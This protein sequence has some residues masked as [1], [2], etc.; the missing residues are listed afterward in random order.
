[1]SNRS[2][3]RCGGSSPLWYAK[4]DER[5]GSIPSI[6]CTLARGLPCKRTVRFRDSWSY[7]LSG[8]HLVVAQLGLYAACPG[9][10]GADLKSVGCKRLAGSNPVRSAI[11]KTKGELLMI[12][13]TIE[14]YQNRINLLRSRSEVVNEKLIKKL[15]R[16]IRHLEAG[17]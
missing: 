3:M 11:I 1:M 16:K 12:T 4:S 8:S 5:D 15:Q 7:R 9:G 17:A 10:E 13:R 14:H 2:K 6:G